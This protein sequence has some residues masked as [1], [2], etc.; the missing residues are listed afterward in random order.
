MSRWFR[1]Y[2]DALNDPKILKLSD[3]LYRIWVGLLCVASKND[4]FLPSIEDLGLLL[5]IKPAKMREAMQSLTK[6]G[7]IDDDGVVAQP[8]NWDGR[9]FKSDT[10]NERVKRHRERKCNVTVTPPET[11]QRQI[12]ETEKKE[13]REDALL[14]EFET[15]FWPIWPNKVGKP[16]ALAKFRS[17]RKRASLQSIVDGVFAYIRDKPPDRPWLNPA[18]FLHQSRWEDQPATV[19]ISNGKPKSALIQAADNLIQRIAIFDGPP[20]GVRSD[21]SEDPPRL[22]SHG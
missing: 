10:S 12:T 17:A 4:G 20:N 19:S 5:R 7:L 1:F 9:Q 14:I 22:L 15:S 13:T 6:S 2:D 11:E 18:T 8:H 16:A 3:N 21:E